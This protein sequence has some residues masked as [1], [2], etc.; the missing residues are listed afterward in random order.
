MRKEGTIIIVQNHTVVK[1]ISRLGSSDILFYT[2]VNK[3]MDYTIHIYTH[4][5]LRHTYHAPPP[6]DKVE[7]SES[8]AVS[9]CNSTDSTLSA[10][11]LLNALCVGCVQNIQT[12]KDL[13]TELFY[14][15]E[16]VRG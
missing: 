7:Y 9:I 11:K 3:T 10:F 8:S 14:S 6:P 4:L 12:L 13:L 5:H 1:G 16:G 2:Y 15:G